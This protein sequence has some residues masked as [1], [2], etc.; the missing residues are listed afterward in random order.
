MPPWRGKG[1]R[2]IFYMSMMILFVKFGSQ[3][4]KCHPFF[5]HYKT[6][7]KQTICSQ[8][9]GYSQFT[10]LKCVVISKFQPFGRIPC[11]FP[12]TT[13]LSS[14]NFIYTSQSIFQTAYI[15]SLSKYVC[16]LRS[17]V[18]RKQNY[19]NFWYP[20]RKKNCSTNLH[21]FTYVSI[22][23]LPGFTKWGNGGIK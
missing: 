5:T 13:E 2:A 10:Y 18:K 11:L 12:S 9:V 14:W 21:F 6:A 7:N 3:S 15:Y 4:S 16:S 20:F 19:A 23:I 17:S 1:N 22:Y 8:Y